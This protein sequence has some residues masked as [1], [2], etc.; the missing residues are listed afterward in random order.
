MRLP[1]LCIARAILHEN[2]LPSMYWQKRRKSYHPKTSQ[3]ALALGQK[4]RDVPRKA[5]EC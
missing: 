3:E 1:W 4:G 2:D 5:D